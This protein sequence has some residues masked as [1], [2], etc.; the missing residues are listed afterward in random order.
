[1]AFNYDIIGELGLKKNCN[2]SEVKSRINF[3]RKLLAK[4]KLEQK[5]CIEEYNTHSR[6]LGTYEDI[7][8]KYWNMF[9][10][11]WRKNYEKNHKQNVGYKYLV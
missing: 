9:R 4:A 7:V 8:D 10:T 5:E 2:Q 11:T 1:M 6:K 3:V